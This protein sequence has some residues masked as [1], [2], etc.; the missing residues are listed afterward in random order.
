M[1]QEWAA[2]GCQK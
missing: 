1:L 2:T